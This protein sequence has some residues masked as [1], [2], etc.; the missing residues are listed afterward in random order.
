MLEGN[1]C[2]ARY[3][4]LSYQH[5]PSHDLPFVSSPLSTLVYRK[6]IAS[7]YGKAAASKLK[8]IVLLREPVARDYS[9]YQHGVREELYLGKVCFFLPFAILSLHP[10]RYH[11]IT[12]IISLPL[13]SL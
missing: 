9:S 10:P 11:S 3:S 8:F 2:S 6:R 5:L 12:I 13:F 1:L 4:L 7:G